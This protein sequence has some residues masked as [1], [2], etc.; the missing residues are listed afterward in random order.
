MLIY[1]EIS[2]ERR[3]YIEL[4]ILIMNMHEFN[5][6]FITKRSLNEYKKD[7]FYTPNAIVLARL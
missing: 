7:H 5:I 3:Y 6:L 2:H 4:I 1:I